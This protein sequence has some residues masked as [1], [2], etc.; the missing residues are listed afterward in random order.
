MKKGW[1]NSLLRMFLQL[2]WLHYLPSA[3]SNSQA[4]EIRLD[5]PQLSLEC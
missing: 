2:S 1:E 3:Q 4:V 5:L